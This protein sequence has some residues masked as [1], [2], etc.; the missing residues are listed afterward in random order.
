MNIS[1]HDI[2]DWSPYELQ[3]QFLSIDDAVKYKANQTLARITANLM[4]K[5]TDK[6]GRPIYTAMDVYDYL[7]GKRVNAKDEIKH[8]NEFLDRLNNRG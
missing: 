1:V 2:F 5:S 4:A 7:I 3:L 8:T 6:S